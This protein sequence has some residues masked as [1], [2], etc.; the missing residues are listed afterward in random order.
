M[1]RYHING[2]WYLGFETGGRILLVGKLGNA[3]ECISMNHT[4]FRSE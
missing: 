1:K 2:V 3:G 4:R